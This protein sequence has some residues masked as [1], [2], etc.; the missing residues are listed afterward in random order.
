MGLSSRE[1]FTLLVTVESRIL[2]LS[3]F[4]FMFLG[5]LRYMVMVWYVWWRGDV[6]G[7][8]RCS[9]C[10]GIVIHGVAHFVGW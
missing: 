4:L 2:H 3:R 5:V 7:D 9:T 6:C 1:N 10:G 8:G